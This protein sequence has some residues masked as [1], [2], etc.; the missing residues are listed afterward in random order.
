[1]SKIFDRFKQAKPWQAEFP[2]TATETD[3]LYCFRL[4][5]DR[6][7]KEQEWSGH[8]W[9]VG[10]D[11]ASV[12]GSYLN[13]QEFA[14]RHLL[15]RAV[16]N[17]KLVELPAFKIYATPDDSLIGKV[18]IDDHDYEPQVSQLFREHLRPGMGV[19]D[20]GANI[21]YF[22]LLAASI[23]GPTC[24]V[25]SWEPSSD[26]VRALSASRAANGFEH[27]EV[28][29]AAATDR[30][31]LLKYFRNA[32]N[33]AVRGVEQTLPEDLLSAETV[34]GLRIDDFVRRD[35]NVGLLKIDVEGYEFKA[36]LGA[37]E[38][39]KRCR[40][41]VISEFSPAALEDS[42]G[43]TGREYLELFTQLGYDI[44]CITDTG[45]EAATIDSVMSRY[46]ATGKDHLDVVLRPGK[47]TIS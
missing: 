34:M 29:Q 17:W 33:G 28:I 10:E 36:I 7:P 25:Q 44:S 16:G 26:N 22:S 24:F 5:L 46:K 9:R 27:I 31:T 15:D 35:S 6:K 23:V 30:N 4:L 13:S 20:I 14:K 37:M 45:I 39:I 3:I 1:M 8:S 41:V 19:L 2:P 21:G 47:N 18:I 42:C 11:I 12:V 43:A 40:P 38:T 32:L